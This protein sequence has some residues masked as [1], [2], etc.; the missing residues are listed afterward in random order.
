MMTARHPRERPRRVHR[1]PRHAFRRRRPASP[2]PMTVFRSAV[3]AAAW[4]KPNAYGGGSGGQT[5]QGGQNNGRRHGHGRNSRRHRGRGAPQREHPAPQQQHHQGHRSQS[6]PTVRLPDGST[7]RV[8][9]AMCVAPSAS[10]LAEAGDAYMPTHIVRQFA[11][12]RG[13]ALSATVGRD[14]R[15]R[16]TW[17]MSSRSMARIRRSRRGAPIS[18]PSPRRIP[19]ASS[20]SRP[21]GRQGRPGSDPTRDRPDRAR[22]A[23]ASAR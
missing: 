4:A 2:H 11:L 17:S 3:R 18:A 16:M 13:D 12:R 5:P 23:M 22:S 10:Y 9:A 19:I 14:Q 1:R 21:A 6:S 8:M 7:R 15:G 20:P